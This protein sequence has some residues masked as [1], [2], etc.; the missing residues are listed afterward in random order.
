MA[1]AILSSWWWLAELE[2]EL[3]RAWEQESALALVAESEP[4]ETEQVL[5]LVVLASDQALELRRGTVCH[6]E[7]ACHRDRE[8]VLHREV[9]AVPEQA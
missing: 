8:L 6:L 1:T 9:L 2:S 5:E 3:G 7:Q 4:V